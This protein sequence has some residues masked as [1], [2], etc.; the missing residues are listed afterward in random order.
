L[1]ELEIDNDGFAKSIQGHEFWLIINIL[2][3]RWGNTDSTS[4]KWC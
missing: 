4:R 1:Y 2:S 3:H